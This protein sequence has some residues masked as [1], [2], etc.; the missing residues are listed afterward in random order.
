[1]YGTV[2]V[3][4]GP[5]LEGIFGN[6][7]NIESDAL[8]FLIVKNIVSFLLEGLTPAGPPR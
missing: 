2:T 4:T 8:S 3:V 5:E 1:M 7:V 6:T